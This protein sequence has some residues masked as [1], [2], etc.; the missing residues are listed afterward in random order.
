MK[1]YFLQCGSLK[2]KRHFIMMNMGL[3]EDYEIPVPYFLLD[4]PKGKVLFDGGNA[5]EVAQ[6]ARKHWGAVVEAYLPVMSEEDFVVNQLQRMNVDVSEIKYVV[7]SHLHLDHSGAIGHFP[8]ATYVV[9]RRELEYAYTPDFF[10]KGA[11]IRPDFDR[12]VRWFTLNGYEDSGY[13]L[14]GDGSIRMIFTPGHAP[15]HQSMI[16]DLENSGRMVLT[17]DAAYTLEHMDNNVLPGLIY[18]AGDVV[19]SLEYIRQLREQGATV[20]TGHDPIA[21][22]EWRKGPAEFYD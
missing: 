19:R 12:D 9:Q 17:A 16:V 18:N 14:F 3:N 6:D 15:G 2:T 13:D 5:L 22:P 21:W 20:V 1:L 11:Y 10:Q 7:Q 4:H 8:N